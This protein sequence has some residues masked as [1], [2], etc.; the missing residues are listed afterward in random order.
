[1][2]DERA[3]DANVEAPFDLL[4]ECILAAK[5]HPESFDLPQL[6]DDILNRLTAAERER[7]ALKAEVADHA[8]WAKRVADPSS[9]EHIPLATK[10]AEL[11][12]ECEW[13][14]ILLEALIKRWKLDLSRRPSDNGVE[15]LL[16]K[17][18]SDI[19][20]KL[21]NGQGNPAR[22]SDE[23]VAKIKEAING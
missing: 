19:A 15:W 21:E 17:F 6:F 9:P 14:G 11:V 23:I 4:V 12:K 1:M 3:S 5:V 7:D 16:W 2:T 20:F 8:E 18:H 10:V 22:P 13:R